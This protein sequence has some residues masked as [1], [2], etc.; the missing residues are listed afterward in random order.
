MT[1][2]REVYMAKHK[3]G[4]EGLRDGIFHSSYTAGEPVLMAG[5]MLI[6]NGAVQAVRCDSGHYKPGSINCALFLQGLGMFGV[7]LRKVT[8]YDFKG[9]ESGAAFDLLKSNMSWDKLEAR[10]PQ[11]QA[12]RQP[13]AVPQPP[14]IENPS[15]TRVYFTA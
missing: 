12:P 7:N 11:P 1:L 6:R 4:G 3:I 2:D 14:S 15:G 13:A 8:V 10:I 5:T 9:K